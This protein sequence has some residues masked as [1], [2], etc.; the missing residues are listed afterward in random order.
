M[1]V[2][3]TNGLPT[4]PDRP[5]EIRITV[6][7]LGTEGPGSGVI[8]VAWSFEAGCSVDMVELRREVEGIAFDRSRQ[9]F[10][11]HIYRQSY[12]SYDWGASHTF[13]EVT[14]EVAQGLG[15]EVIAAGLLYAAHRITRGLPRTPA[16]LSI[17]TADHSARWRIKVTYDIPEDSL[18]G[19]G[20]KETEDGGYL[21]RYRAGDSYVYDVEV[22]PTESGFPLTRLGR[23]QDNDQS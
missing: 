12:T 22:R 19:I 3:V 20:E 23:F 4:M 9:V 18:E 13:A 7:Q 15:E 8:E 2:D 17:Q 1:N 10:H 14:L 5:I 21:L 6:V 16:P 11:P